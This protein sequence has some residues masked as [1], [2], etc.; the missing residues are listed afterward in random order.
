MNYIEIKALALSYADKSNASEV[1]NNIDN[2]L[3]IVESKINRTLK[4]Q[5]MQSSH[6]ITT[7]I[8]EEYYVLPDDF[9]GLVDIEIR[10]EDTSRTRYTLHYL[11]P[12][13][14]NQWMIIDDDGRYK[15]YYNLILGKLHIMPPKDAQLLE[16]VYYQRITALDAVNPENWISTIFP[17]LYVFGLLVEI[18]SFLKDPNAASLWNERYLN[19]MTEVT[20]DDTE[21]STSGTSLQVKVG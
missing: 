21:V 9:G 6:Q 18:S 5:K 19:V 13:Q 14:M 17:D 16:L 7:D 10:A 15:I 20:A 2:F 12:E 11:S 8:N 4:T 3:R 1:V